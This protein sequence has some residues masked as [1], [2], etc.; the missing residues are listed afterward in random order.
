MCVWKYIGDFFLCIDYR[1][2]ENWIK[3]ENDDSCQWRHNSLDSG[4]FDD[5][6]KRVAIITWTCLQNNSDIPIYIHIPILC[7]Y[8]KNLWLERNSHI[9]CPIY[10]TLKDLH[11]LQW[12]VEFH[13]LVKL[14]YNK[15]FFRG[16]RRSAEVNFVK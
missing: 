8:Y 5:L 13:L 3:C 7:V 14:Y 12:K 11:S 4:F 9:C 10:I 15:K 1:Y 16:F 6:L 2:K